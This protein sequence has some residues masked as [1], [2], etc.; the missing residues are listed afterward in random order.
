M[1]PDQPDILATALAA[2]AAGLSVHPCAEDGSK[3]PLPWFVDGVDEAG[4]PKK[5]WLHPAG[6]PPDEALVRRWY[7]PR[8]GLGLRCGSE[9]NGLEITEFDDP[10]VY[11]SFREAAQACGLGELLELIEAGYLESSPAGGVHLAYYCDELRG[12]TKLAREPREP[13]EG[14]S[15]R[16]VTLIETRG[17]NGYIVIAPSGGPVHRSGRPYVLLRGSLGTIATITG[18][19][20][21]A[22]WAL[23]RTFDRM[24][25][26]APAEPRP[27]GRPPAD[28]KLRPGDD[29]NQRA[30][31][32]DIL[33]DAKWTAVYRRGETTY[34]RRPGKDRGVSATT[35]HHGSG[36]LWVFSGS[37]EFEAER[38]YSKLGAYALLRHGGNYDEA[39]RAL[40][41]EGYGSPH[42]PRDGRPERGP[43]GGGEAPA[44]IG[45]TPTTGG[46]GDGDGGEVV[47][48]WPRI[49]FRAFHGIAGELAWAADPHTEADPIAVLVQVLIGFANAVG[50]GPH[51]RA[52]AT[53]HYLSMFAALVG[54]TAAG[55]KGSS[56]DVAHYFLDQVDEDWSRHRIGSGLSSG[57]G[58][59]HQVRDRVVKLE[60]DKEVVVDPGVADK[61]LL[62]LESELGRTLRVMAREGSTLSSVLRQAWDCPATISSATKNNSLRATEAFVSIVGHITR[63]ELTALLARTDAA[64]GLANRFA[65]FCVRRSKELPE[66]GEFHSV[67]WAPAVARLRERFH[68]A[69]SVMLMRRDDEARAAWNA[70][71]GDLTAGKPG[72]LGSVLGRAEPQVMRFAC[73]YALLDGSACVRLAHLEAAL[74]LWEYA[75]ASA[76]FVFGDSLADPKADK[77]LAAL[78]AS[79]AGLTRTQITADVFKGHLKGAELA[80]S[81][82]EL[83]SLGLI[84]RV[85]APTGRPGRAPEVW[86]AGRDYAPAEPG[87]INLVPGG[88]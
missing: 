50:R 17:D 73:I 43:G 21:D 44:V 60:Q 48:L 47:D 20:R 65:W 75:E 74:A 37:T 35:N 71:Y 25:R 12:N 9:S 49:D 69:R 79:P 36:L 88:I 55:R 30:S 54:P 56:W 42:E 31:W 46:D 53:A 41:K 78:K 1:S 28:G 84:H 77:L 32:D 58:L 24:P 80:A 51:W 72:L 11:A 14:D 2:L 29:F 8:R 3:A 39:A 70:V 52:G 34:W 57:E 38:S 68:H 27:K 82:Q 62:M 23:A 15:R 13:T 64:N 18:E 4:R 16:V 87:I 63:T 10:D 22:L 81:L 66:G 19:E 85:V 7:G 33:G 86:R 76:R 45:M 61:R 83:L 59:I 5:S 67:D 26:P 6:C 40:R